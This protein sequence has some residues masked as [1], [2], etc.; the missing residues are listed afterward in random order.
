MPVL[1]PEDAITKR[2]VDMFMEELEAVVSARSKWFNAVGREPIPRG[3]RVT[4]TDIKPYMPKWAPTYYRNGKDP[5]GNPINF[6]GQGLG[7]VRVSPKTVNAFS[8]FTGNEDETKRYWKDYY[9]V[10]EM[11]TNRAANSRNG[12]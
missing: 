5:L 9:P 3:Y 8:R 11:V 6:G 10:S 4:W 2:D 7:G 1:V 12:Y